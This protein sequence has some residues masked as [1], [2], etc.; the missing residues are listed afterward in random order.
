MR[1]E[2]FHGLPFHLDMAESGS[3]TVAVRCLRRTTPMGATAARGTPGSSSRQT[4]RGILWPICD[5][6]SLL[7][8]FNQ[9]VYLSPPFHFASARSLSLLSL[10]RLDYII[11]WPFKGFVEGERNPDANFNY[12]FLYDSVESR[13]T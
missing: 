12:D 11:D 7:C 10:R 9:L 8:E 4:K 5:Q 2:A 3:E 1:K 6:S 13:S